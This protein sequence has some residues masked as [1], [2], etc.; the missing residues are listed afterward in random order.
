MK[1]ISK[2]FLQDTLAEFHLIC[3]K[4]GA[5]MDSTKEQ[6]IDDEPTFAYECPCC[7]RSYIISSIEYPLTKNKKED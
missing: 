1:E 5:I 4:C 3:K 6:I 7:N 2:I